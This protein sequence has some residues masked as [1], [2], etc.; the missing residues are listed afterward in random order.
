MAPRISVLLPYRNAAPT[1]EEA[2][3]GVLDQRGAGDVEVLAIDDGSTD[4]GR[5]VVDR[6]AARHAGLHSLAS[7][8]PGLVGALTTGLLHCRAPFVARMDA[9]DVCLPGRFAACA[10]M[11]E[12]QPELAVAA[13]QVEAFPDEA[14]AD[15]MR[16]YVAW[17]NRLV[18]AAD[19]A[20]ELFIESPLCHPS[21]MIRREALDRVGPW[22]EGDFPEDYDLWL[23]LDGAGW[24]LAKVPAILLRWRHAS[25]RATFADPRYG[26]DRF[27]AVKA[28]H[29][30]HPLRAIGR[31]VAI[32]GAGRTGKRLARELEHSGL[33]AHRFI[34]IDPKKIGGT[35][36][37]RPVES[38][39][40]IRAGG[41]CVV[42][43]VSQWGAR[44][45]VRQQLVK[46]RCREGVD[47]LCAA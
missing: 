10:D 7:A 40:S 8:A 22:R 36:R 13:T 3:D 35:A 30:A 4:G 39:A 1:L 18:S 11:L 43:A 25:G 27:V 23:R 34:D 17:Q 28:P 29:L 44:D 33:Q 37:G 21:V 38:S 20:R 12:R 14:L 46:A 32:W 15:G 5:D 45:L 41:E 16:R 6:L 9:D 19:H 24:D 47:F 42:V 2:L 31:P 26:R